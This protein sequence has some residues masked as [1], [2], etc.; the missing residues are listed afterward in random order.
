EDNTDFKQNQQQISHKI[1]ACRKWNSSILNKNFPAKNS[2]DDLRELYRRQA[3]PTDNCP[4]S[5]SCVCTSTEAP[6]TSE[7]ITS[8]QITSSTTTTPL[9]STTTTTVTTTTTTTTAT[10]TTTTT[11]TTATTTIAATTETTTTSTETTSSSNYVE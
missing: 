2:F 8:E 11:T 4:A 3:Q 7:Q 6:Q 9:S 5:C 1:K 10:A